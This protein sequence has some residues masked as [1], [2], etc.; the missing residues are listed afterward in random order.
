M[1]VGKPAAAGQAHLKRISQVSSIFVLC[2]GRCKGCRPRGSMHSMRAQ[3]SKASSARSEGALVRWALQGG[4]AHLRWRLGERCLVRWPLLGCKI[5]VP[6]LA[7]CCTL[8][9][10]VSL[11]PQASTPEEFRR[12]TRPTCPAGASAT[13]GRAACCEAAGQ[14]AHGHLA[15]MRQ[16]ER[17]QKHAVVACVPSLS[18]PCYCLNERNYTLPSHKYECCCACAQLSS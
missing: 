3:G 8:N 16:V 18:S 7:L 6:W 1:S 5:P 15:L 11:G 9:R 4:V 2:M 17:L 13:K 12:V 14:T 10:T